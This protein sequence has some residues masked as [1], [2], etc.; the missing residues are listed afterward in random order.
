MKSPKGKSVKESDVLYWAPD[1]VRFHD[2]AKGRIVDV[3]PRPSEVAAWL[4]CGRKGV[5][6]VKLGAMRPEAS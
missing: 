6:F 5:E 3:A 4:W 1:C 2:R